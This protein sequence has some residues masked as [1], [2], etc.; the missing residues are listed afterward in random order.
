MEVGRRSG[1]AGS[2]GQGGDVVAAFQFRPGGDAAAAIEDWRVEAGGAEYVADTAVIAG[3][4]Q[5]D[6]AE[7]GRRAVIGD[8]RRHALVDSPKSEQRRGGKECV[9]T[10]RSRW[11]P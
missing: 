3:Q 6:T 8:H 9:S 11:S 7:T 5:G 4:W 10:C 1:R 2:A